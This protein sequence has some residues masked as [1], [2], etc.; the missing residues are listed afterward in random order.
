MTNILFDAQD[1]G[2]KFAGGSAQFMIEYLYQALG[3]SDSLVSD[4]KIDEKDPSVG[5]FSS[6]D[7]VEFYPSSV[8]WTEEL[9]FKGREKG[10]IYVPKACETT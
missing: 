4:N 6:F 10:Y 7:Q 5:K 9:N 1:N 8:N 2:H 3:Y